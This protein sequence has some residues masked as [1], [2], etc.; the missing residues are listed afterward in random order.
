MELFTQDICW[1]YIAESRY[2]HLGRSIIFCTEEE[3]ASSTGQRL[4]KGERVVYFRRFDNTFDALAHKLMLE[5][6]SYATVSCLIQKQQMC[7]KGA[8]E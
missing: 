7:L 5:R 4:S 1:I 6:L 8:T 2:S 3:F